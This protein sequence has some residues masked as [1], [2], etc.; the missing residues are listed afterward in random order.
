MVPGK[1]FVKKVG[2]KNYIKENNYMKEI[3]ISI[4][5]KKDLIKG[6]IIMIVLFAIGYLIGKFIANIVKGSIL[7]Q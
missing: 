5:K 3:S 7:N 6:S 1:T 4:P 2:S